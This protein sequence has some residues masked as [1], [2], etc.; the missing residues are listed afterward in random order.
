[1]L[2]KLLF[3]KL[4]FISVPLKLCSISAGVECHLHSDAEEKQD[5]AQMKKSPHSFTCSTI[6]FFYFPPT[7][8][9]FHFHS[10]P[11]QCAHLSSAHLI[12]LSFTN[13][14]LSY[15]YWRLLFGFFCPLLFLQLS[16]ACSSR[17]N[18]VF[19]QHFEECLVWWVREGCHRGWA[20]TA[21]ILSLDWIYHWNNTHHEYIHHKTI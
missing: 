19:K 10:L 5:M 21:H 3:T 12:L 13:P 15:F 18:S 4:H 20:I 11:L 2:I 6:T 17:E 9:S 1:M 16:A 7:F 8:F 14:P